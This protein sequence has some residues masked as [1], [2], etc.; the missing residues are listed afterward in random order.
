[1]KIVIIIMINYEI[2][3]KKILTHMKMIITI[4]I[5]YKIN[6]KKKTKLKMEI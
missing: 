4:M 2:N 6:M 1:M 5:H 3:M